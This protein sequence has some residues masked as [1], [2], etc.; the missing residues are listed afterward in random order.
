VHRKI[1]NSPSGTIGIDPARRDAKSTFEGGSL[2]VSRGCPLLR[3][4]GKLS[5]SEVAVFSPS[6]ALTSIVDLSE[7]IADHRSGNP[8]DDVALALQAADQRFCFRA[9]DAIELRSLSP[10]R[11]LEV[12]SAT[13]GSTD[14]ATLLAPFFN[15]DRSILRIP[16]PCGA[17]LAL[18]SC[19]EGAAVEIA[20]RVAPLPKEA[21]KEELRLEVKKSLC[22]PFAAASNVVVCL[23]AVATVVA[24]PPCIAPAQCAKVAAARAMAVDPASQASADAK[25]AKLTALWGEVWEKAL[26]S[27]DASSAEIWAS[28][29]ALGFCADTTATT[30]G[31]PSTNSM[32]AVSSVK[33]TLE[34]PSG[35]T[36]WSCAWGKRV[37]A[38]TI[39]ARSMGLS[40]PAS[41]LVATVMELSEDHALKVLRQVRLLL[42]ADMPIR[43]ERF[44]N[45]SVLFNGATLLL[46]VPDGERSPARRIAFDLCQEAPVP[47]VETLSAVDALSKADAAGVKCAVDVRNHYLWAWNANTSTVTRWRDRLPAPSWKSLTERFTPLGPSLASVAALTHRRSSVLSHLLA[48]VPASSSKARA[49]AA[50]VV[51]LTALEC[52]SQLYAPMDWEATV[53]NAESLHSISISSKYLP[54]KKSPDISVISLGIPVIVPQSF[55]DL[56]SAVHIAVLGDCYE[57]QGAYEV[58]MG[59]VAAGAERVKDILGHVVPG[60]IVLLCCTEVSSNRVHALEDALGCVGMEPQGENCPH[61]AML[62]IGIRGAAPGTALRSFGKSGD[63]LSLQTFAPVRSSP[64]ALALTGTTVESLLRILAVLFE[65]SMRV[66]IPEERA[67]SKMGLLAALQVLKTHMFRASLLPPVESARVLAE[68]LRARMKDLLLQLI[69]S[70]ALLAD[71]PVEDALLGLFVSAVSA[72]YPTLQDLQALLFHYVDLYKRNLIARIEVFILE[73]VLKRMSEIGP[74]VQLLQGGSLELTS[75]RA[76]DEA[77]PAGAIDFFMA[78]EHIYLGEMQDNV[79]ASSLSAT[80]VASMEAF[81]KLLLTCGAEGY[82]SVDAKTVP[83]QTRQ[84]GAQLLAKTVVSLARLCVSV[85]E[86]SLL[87]SDAALSS[88]QL[89][90]SPLRTLLPLVLNV[91]AGL[92]SCHRFEFIQPIIDSIGEMVSQLSQVHAKLRTLLAALPKAEC[93]YVDDVEDAVVNSQVFESSHPYRS[94][95]DEETEISFPGAT[96]ITIVFDP[97]SRTENGC[98]YIQFRDTHGNSLHP[99]RLTGRDGSE[100][101][102]GCL[103]CIAFALLSLYFCTVLTVALVR[104]LIELAWLRGPGAAGG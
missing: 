16:A 99:E 66:A 56:N 75:Q 96:S 71:K 89:E 29:S 64:L 52:K 34:A 67:V 19:E 14:V 15:E 7:V 28:M 39:L 82:V 1:R 84:A 26:I 59:D 55:T 5:S 83:Q 27:P 24:A 43:R 57:A 45:A 46:T 31:E 11:V 80:A 44:E 9:S 76:A 74:L 48:Q 38:Q 18:P 101:S 61:R 22:L 60:R 35:S 85:V 17:A 50:A 95:M 63:S 54:G 6:L 51:A 4:R 3:H 2:A 100:V 87:S 13:H 25:T 77:T 92:T 10:G 42:P 32:L 86:R 70:E 23:E 91:L 94:N 69:R 41:A 58:A 102:G 68:P 79:K 104:T 49:A 33:L 65:E 30:T 47:V 81:C 88:E 40:T 97:R 37:D 21:R 98:D 103:V 73:F 12:C 36:E 78:L 93:I 72:L 8:H 53:D 62:V 20:C 90:K